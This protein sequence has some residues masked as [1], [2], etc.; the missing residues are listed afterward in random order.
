M[1]DFGFFSWPE[2][3]V[4]AYTEVR[5]KSRA[6]EEALGLRYNGTEL[7]SSSWSEKI[8]KLLW[9]G[10]PMVDVRQVGCSP[11]MSATCRMLT[12]L[13]TSQG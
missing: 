2:P 13:A 7:V 6:Y 11:F 9:R 5:D 4:G 1:A 12:V 3:G 10:V 8:P